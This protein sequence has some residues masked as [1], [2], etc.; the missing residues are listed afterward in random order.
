MP[1][2]SN[3]VIDP[4]TAIIRQSLELLKRVLEQVRIRQERIGNQHQLPR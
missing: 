2:S 3:Y 4:E 1:L